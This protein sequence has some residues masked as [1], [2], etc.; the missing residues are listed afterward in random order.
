MFGYWI[1]IL[2]YCNSHDNQLYVDDGDRCLPSSRP[3]SIHIHLIRKESQAIF[4][5]ASPTSYNIQ[6]HSGI[7][8]IKQSI[9]ARIITILDK[10]V[11]SFIQC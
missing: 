5:F 8:I 9:V 4:Q 1:T 3:Y 7:I 11:M 10:C 6:L 2:Y